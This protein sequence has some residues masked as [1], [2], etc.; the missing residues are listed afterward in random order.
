MNCGY[1]EVLRFRAA[2]FSHLIDLSLLHMMYLKDFF[3]I[4]DL[5]IPVPKI[6][7]CFSIM[8]YLPSE[9][10]CPKT[11]EIMGVDAVP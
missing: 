8:D 1:G 5:T 11:D 4:Q 6:D 3:Q 9:I 2:L 10:E 7:P